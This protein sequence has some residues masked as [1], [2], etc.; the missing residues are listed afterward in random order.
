MDYITLLFVRSPDGRNLLVFV[1]LLKTN[2]IFN[3]C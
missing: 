3:M 1:L 2:Y